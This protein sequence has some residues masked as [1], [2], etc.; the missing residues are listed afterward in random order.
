MMEDIESLF[1]EYDG[2]S[3]WGLDEIETV[4]CPRCETAQE[5]EVV[6][7]DEVQVEV[8]ENCGTQLE[9]DWGL[10]RQG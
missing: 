3:R 10:W 8:C 5:I 7:A 6:D 2:V 4:V 9:I 1:F